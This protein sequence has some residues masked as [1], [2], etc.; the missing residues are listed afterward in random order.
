MHYLSDCGK[1]FIAQG[2]E[3][4]G[5]LARCQA[6]CNESDVLEGIIL[7]IQ[8]TKRAAPELVSGGPKS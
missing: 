4:P 6:A 2:G 8:I 3:S 1:L 7:I 5:R